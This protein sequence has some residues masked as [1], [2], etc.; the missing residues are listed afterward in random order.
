MILKFRKYLIFCLIFANFF[1]HGW[2]AMPDV[3]EFSNL[4][5]EY[6]PK[7]CLQLEEAYGKGLMSEGGVE[8]IEHMFDQI[9]LK[10]K[11]ALDIGS[12]LG[13]VA[14][15]LSEKYGT[16]ITGLEVNSWMLAEAEKRTPNSLKSKVHF[17]LSTGNTNWPLPKDKYDLVYSKGVLTH[18]DENGKNGM[19]KE[20]HRLL[21]NEGL[22]VVT[23]WLS[24]DNKTW[25][26]NIK[27]L[28][29]LGNLVLYPESE[30]GYLDL[31]KK[32]GF[33]IVSVR[34]DSPAY[35]KYNQEIIDRLEGQ[36]QSGTYADCFTKEDLQASIDAYIFILDALK[37]GELK[38]L[39]FVVQK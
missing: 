37:E 11:T 12:G 32:N 26:K 29:G 21:K 16:Q 14:F 25:G 30:A 10:D 31:F 15:Y 35:L 36:K 13:G 8:G 1:A 19:F 7:Y 34:D 2:C 22:F 5:E 39:R 28:I 24:S 3:P 27:K 18:V 4:E 33:K 38:V 6:T 17:L 9:Q 20:C 23:D